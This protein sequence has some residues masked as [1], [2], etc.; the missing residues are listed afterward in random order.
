M[1]QKNKKNWRL[2]ARLNKMKGLKATTE[3][4]TMEE[5]LKTLLQHLAEFVKS[6]IKLHARKKKGQRYSPELKSLAI[7][8]YHASGKSYRLLS[9]IF[10]L[11]SKAALKR[12]ISKLPTK[13]G[14]TQSSLNVIKSKVE[15]LDPKEKICTLCMDEMSLKTHLHYRHT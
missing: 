8:L 15:Q 10:I 6:Q 2:E 5:A 13:T 12:Y 4:K 11:P 3:K 7:S 1:H 9:K 14:I